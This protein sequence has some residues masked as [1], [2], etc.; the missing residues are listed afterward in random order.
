MAG[1]VLCEGVCLNI[2]RYVVQT[3]VC[4]CGQARSQKIFGGASNAT[5]DP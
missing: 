3:C 5:V 2:E 1:E 4:V